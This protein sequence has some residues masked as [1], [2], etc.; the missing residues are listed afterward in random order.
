MRIGLA[1][2]ILAACFSLSSST[3]CLAQ[4]Q[5]EGGEGNEMGNSGAPVHGGGPGGNPDQPA[6]GQGK[7]G[8]G[9]GGPQGGPG[10]GNGPGSQQGGGPGQFRRMQEGSNAGQTGPGQ[11]GFNDAERAARRQRMMARFDTNHDGVLDENEK[12]Q[13]RAF[14]E[15]R[16]AER[17]AR[18][19]GQSSGGGGWHRPNGGFGG[20]PGASPNGGP[21]GGPHGGQPGSGGNQDQ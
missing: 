7:W 18:E 14:M 9:G 12:A 19:G 10:P 21:A 6:F 1:Q 17:Q 15:Q 2:V 13:M 16:R 8:Q 20:P 5:P 3:A 11:G 4:D